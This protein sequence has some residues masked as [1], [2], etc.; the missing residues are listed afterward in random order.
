[1]L[2]FNQTEEEINLIKKPVAYIIRDF[3]MSI[4]NFIGNLLH[5]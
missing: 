1:M 5:K 4:I 3:I 2:Q